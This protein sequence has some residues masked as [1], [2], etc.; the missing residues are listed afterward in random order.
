LANFYI[1]TLLLTF[2]VSRQLLKRRIV[3]ILHRPYVKIHSHSRTDGRLTFLS[4]W[5]AWPAK[6]FDEA[7]PLANG[8]ADEAASFHGLKREP[9]ATWG[10]G[11][12]GD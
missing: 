9:S 7:R 10:E 3:V 1:I 5:T 4:I 11:A 2:P 8:F 6:R 12:A